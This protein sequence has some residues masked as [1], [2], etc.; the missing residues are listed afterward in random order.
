M[1]CGTERRGKT[2][3]QERRLGSSR[4]SRTLL[5]QSWAG[6]RTR[7]WEAERPLRPARSLPTPHLQGHA[8]R[9]PRGLMSRVSTRQSE[10]DSDTVRAPFCYRE[11]WGLG[12]S[13]SV[14]PFPRGTCAGPGARSG[15]GETLSAEPG[16][17]PD[18]QPTASTGLRGPGC[19]REPPDFS[20][21]DFTKLL[22][23]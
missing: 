7:W 10:M 18:S 23:K 17:V 20:T 22:R 4:A 16:S 1:A 5:L 19:P 6:L 11:P 14:G 8:A 15:R 12:R 21:V 3:L 2:G 9:G 13:P